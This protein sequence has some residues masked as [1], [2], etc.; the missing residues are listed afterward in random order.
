MIQI[1]TPWDGTEELNK[2]RITANG[3]FD[4]IRKYL[5]PFSERETADDFKYRKSLTYCPAFAE[6]AVQEII[7]DI[8]VRLP[9]VVRQSNDKTYL[10]AVEGKLGGVDFKK[11]TMS[12]FMGQFVIPELLQMKR[13]GVFVD[14]FEVVGQT[15]AENK[16]K[17]PYLYVYRAEEILAWNYNGADLESLMVEAKVPVYNQGFIESYISEY[18]VFSL[19]PGKGMRYQKW[20]ADSDQESGELKTYDEILPDIFEIPF[21]I[22]EISHSLYKN[23]A[24]YQIALLNAESADISYMIRSNFPFYVEQRDPRAESLK[25]FKAKTPEDQPEE[26][27]SEVEV[28]ALRGRWYT[29]GSDAPSFIAPPTEP[30]IA[31]MQKEAVLKDDIRKIV[32]LNL[33][34]LEPVHASAESR[35]IANSPKESGLQAIGQCLQIGENALLKFWTAFTGADA[36]L[37]NVVYPSKMCL[38]TEDERIAAATALYPTIDMVPSI[39]GKRIIANRIA[40][41]LIGVNEEV[42]KQIDKA[43][44]LSGDALTIKS[45]VEL[46]LVTTATASESRGIASGE[47]D[48]ARTQ[49]QED[50]AAIYAAQA[51]ANPDPAAAKPLPGKEN[52]KVPAPKEPS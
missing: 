13:V 26:Q 17:H 44:Y 40:E 48:K 28:G 23:A 31:A 49:K 25:K 12:R 18:R 51:K 27:S 15:L 38:M 52:G 5:K 46:G 37:N 20:K 36:S 41:L 47:A 43:G 9:D 50:M 39:E 1:R 32:N 11:S 16:D 33:G 30:L 21:H 22:F 19:V 3:G 45:D 34:Q 42:K 4:F 24:D 7:G 8:T 2:Y 10:D 29:Q 35:K 6:A 14:N